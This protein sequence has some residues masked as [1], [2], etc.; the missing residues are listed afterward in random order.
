MTTPVV[1]LSKSMNVM[2]D[3]L[4]KA[5]GIQVATPFLVSTMEVLEYDSKYMQ[6][7]QMPEVGPLPWMSRRIDK[8]K[9]D[10]VIAI[11]HFCFVLDY[12]I[13]FVRIDCMTLC[14]FSWTR[15]SVWKNIYDVY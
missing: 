15:K 5:E 14:A 9:T 3:I 13:V 8:M 7:L 12:V 4:N 2:I 1:K 10:Y 11:V 6:W